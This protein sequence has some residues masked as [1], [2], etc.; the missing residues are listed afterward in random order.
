VEELKTVSLIVDNIQDGIFL[1]N[2]N[3]QLQYLNRAGKLMLQGDGFIRLCEGRI[4]IR[5]RRTHAIVAEMVRGS[6][7]GELPASASRAHPLL[8]Q[9]YPCPQDLGGAGAGLMIVRIKDINRNGEAPTAE[10]LRARMGLSPQQS[11]VMAELARGSTEA[12]VAEKL[13]I[14]LP[15]VH[16]YVRR[17]YDK[18]AIR[19]RAELSALLAKFGFDANP[20]SGSF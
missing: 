9:V 6:R 1:V 16:T 18:F 2:R 12:A 13:G 5:D 11:A 8:I 3:L 14:K 7:G 20:Q 4:E 15:T 17:V 19:S 10:R